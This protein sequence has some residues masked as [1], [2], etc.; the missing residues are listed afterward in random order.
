MWGGGFFRFNGD[1]GAGGEVGVR[2]LCKP[3]GVVV[4]KWGWG[5]GGGEKEEAQGGGGDK[6]TSDIM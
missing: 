4:L 2:R 5:E 6:G 3:A 1:L